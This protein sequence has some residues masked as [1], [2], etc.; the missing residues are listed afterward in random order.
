[1][2]Y[3]RERS[4]LNQKIHAR[5]HG[6]LAKP[7]S[8]AVIVVDGGPLPDFARASRVEL[9]A[10]Q[11]RDRMLRAWIGALG[12]GLHHILMPVCCTSAGGHRSGRPIGFARSHSASAAAT[13]QRGQV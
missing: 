12:G 4:S 5:N 3:E 7:T 10:A 6:W 13:P 8:R 1:M 11:S 9:Q 2:P